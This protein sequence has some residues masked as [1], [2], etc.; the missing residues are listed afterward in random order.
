MY[1]IDLRWIVAVLLIYMLAVIV[2]VFCTGCNIERFFSRQR[3]DSTAV[4]KVQ[5]GIKDSLNS[6][7]VSTNNSKSKE[8]YEWWRMIVENMPKGDTAVTVNNIY[9][10]PARVIY[11]GGSGTR[12]EEKQSKDSTWMHQLFSLIKES[13]DSTNRRIDN[14]EKQSKTETKG[15]G[16]FFTLILVMIGAV[17]LFKLMGFVGNNYSIIK[18]K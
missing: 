17:L 3:S 6:G 9:P 10:A 2:L 14:V 1:N 7:S 18:K 16:L 5:T 13:F 4:S 12:Q 8:D 15:L 11:E